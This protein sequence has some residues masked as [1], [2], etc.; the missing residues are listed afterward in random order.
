MVLIAGQGTVS[1]RNTVTTLFLPPHRKRGARDEKMSLIL[2]TDFSRGG[3]CRS[4]LANQSGGRPHLPIILSSWIRKSLHQHLLPWPNCLMFKRIWRKR[5]IRYHSRGLGAVWISVLQ[6]KWRFRNSVGELTRRH[7]FAC[8]K[9][10]IHRIGMMI[11]AARR[12]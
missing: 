5:Q 2:G 3:C 8:K 9:S 1:R 12:K 7:G 4:Y 11:C 10:V 6:Q